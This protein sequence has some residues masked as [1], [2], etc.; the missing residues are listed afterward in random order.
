MNLTT[1]TFSQ[2]VC[3]TTHVAVQYETFSMT[4]SDE[5]YLRSRPCNP[6]PHCF[7]SLSIHRADVVEFKDSP[8]DGVM[9]EQAGIIQGPTHSEQ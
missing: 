5:M 9:V 1:Q 4:K 7:L 8:A 3:H 6:P 2:H